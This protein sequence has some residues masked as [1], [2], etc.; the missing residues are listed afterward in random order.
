M[1]LV[2]AIY[3]DIQRDGLARGLNI[4]TTQ[5]FQ[6]G[7]GLEVIAAG[8]VASLDDIRKSLKAGL[9]GAIIGRALYEGEVDLSQALKIARGGI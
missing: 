9:R 3:T 7:T 4:P 6:E 1:G 5:Q 2:W 8:G